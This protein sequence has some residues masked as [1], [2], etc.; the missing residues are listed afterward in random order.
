MNG[1]GALVGDV[2]CK[3]VPAGCLSVL[4]VAVRVYLRSRLI[5]GAGDLC[6]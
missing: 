3:L 2:P 4:V 6:L 5:L 1:V